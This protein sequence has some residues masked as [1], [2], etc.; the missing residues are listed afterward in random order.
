MFIGLFMLV[1]PK[2]RILGYFDSFH[3]ECPN[4]I[5]DGILSIIQVTCDYNILEKNWDLYSPKDIPQ[6]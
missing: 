4:K 1:L 6:Q 5:L 3:Q 2:R